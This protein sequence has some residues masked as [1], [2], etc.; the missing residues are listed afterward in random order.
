MGL[1]YLLDVNSLKL[2]QHT[3]CHY[4][5]LGFG[6]VNFS[7]V[8]LCVLCGKDLPRRVD[9][10]PGPK[11]INQQAFSALTTQPNWTFNIRTKIYQGLSYLV[12]PSLW[13]TF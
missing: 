10:N 5:F 4:N 8:L 9:S 6:R 3:Y 2:H 11:I 1:N 12:V 13:K 7:S